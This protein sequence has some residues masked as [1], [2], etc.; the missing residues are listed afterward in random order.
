M[1][2]KA[3]SPLQAQILHDAKASLNDGG[4]SEVDGRWIPD[5]PDLT[6]EYRDVDVAILAG[7]GLLQ[8]IGKHPRRHA[9]ITEHGLME[10]DC[11]EG[12]A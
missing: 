9:H 12:A 7:Q 2:D 8:L 3:L 11:L 1:L 10:L 6:T 5:A 4:L